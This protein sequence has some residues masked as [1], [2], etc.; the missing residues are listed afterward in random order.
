MC[1]VLGTVSLLT[2]GAL[3]LLLGSGLYILHCARQLLRG[4]SQ[5]VVNIN[6]GLC[7]LWIS[8]ALLNCPCLVVWLR[9]PSQPSDPSLIHSLCLLGSASI[10]WQ[11]GPATLVLET[12]SARAVSVGLKV[13]SV[14][15]SVFATVSVYRASFVV[16]GV[17][18]MVASL[19]VLNMDW[20]TSQSGQQEGVKE[21]EEEIPTERKRGTLKIIT[22]YLETGE[23]R[24]GLDWELCLTEEGDTAI[25][26]YPYYMCVLN[27]LSTLPTDFLG[28]LREVA[29]IA[30]GFL[31]L[32]VQNIWAQPR[33]PSIEVTVATPDFEYLP[34]N[35]PLRKLHLHSSNVEN[36]EVTK[37]EG[38]L[39]NVKKIFMA[40]IHFHYTFYHDLFLVGKIG[41]GFLFYLLTSCPILLLKTLAGQRQED[42]SDDQTFPPVTI[43]SGA[44]R[45]ILN[46]INKVIEDAGVFVLNY[47]QNKAETKQSSQPPSPSNSSKLSSKIQKTPKSAEP[48]QMRLPPRKAQD[49]VQKEPLQTP[50][51]SMDAFKNEVKIQEEILKIGKEKAKELFSGPAI[52]TG[53]WIPDRIV[54]G[55]R[56]DNQADLMKKVDQNEP[57]EMAERSVTEDRKEIKP[58]VSNFDAPIPASSVFER[59]SA[60][61]EFDIKSKIRI[62][63]WDDPKEPVRDNIHGSMYDIHAACEEEADDEHIEELEKLREISPSPEPQTKYY[64]RTDLLGG[65][66]LLSQAPPESPD[67]KTRYSVKD[68]IAQLRCG[69]FIL[70]PS[71]FN[72]TVGNP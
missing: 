8:V 27:R 45:G 19:A 35:H 20:T 52:V 40:I 69:H 63:G 38:F 13:C 17:F 30:Y 1:A 53:P 54:P 47:T 71:N 44:F 12:R 65:S 60:K 68:E 23:G 50:V 66:S 36:A 25:L 48:P 6:V 32:T 43:I 9:E 42:H 33:N 7:L 14:L 11:Q 18:V 3:S 49:P 21:E 4:R 29:S 72:S 15:V 5:Q 64:R 70:F 59:N 67:I 2:C 39:G 24:E 37:I 41:F 34:D 51:K 62:P 28:D 46:L 58:A 16:S 55:Y 61:S 26:Q 56:E 10:L 31:C 22:S 57:R